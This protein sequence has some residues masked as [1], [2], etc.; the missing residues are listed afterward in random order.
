MLFFILSFAFLPL[1]STF[2]SLN[3]ISILISKQS[4]VSSLSLQALTPSTPTFESDRT[5]IGVDYGP[6]FIGLAYTDIFGSVEP[7]YAITHNQYNLSL[8]AEQI[9][10]VAKD[11]LASEIIVGIP[12][13]TDK[14]DDDLLNPFHSSLSRPLTGFNQLLCLNFSKVLN[15]YVSYHSNNRVRVKLVDEAFT[16][17]EAR[18]RLETEKKSKKSKILLLSSFFLLLVCWLFLHC[19]SC[20]FACFS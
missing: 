14:P 10:K 15:S 18:M 11:K 3:R 12:L 13:N 17:Q 9:Y 4:I 2:I 6:R 1:F 5:R 19:Y 8:I 16:T 7:L 20:V